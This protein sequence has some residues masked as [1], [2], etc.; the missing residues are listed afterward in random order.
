MWRMMVWTDS[1]QIIHN[2]A[3]WSSPLVHRLE[4]AFFGTWHTGFGRGGYIWDW[5]QINYSTQ[6]M[7]NLSLFLWCLSQEWTRADRP[8]A[9]TGT[10]T[11][12]DR[13][14]SLWIK[15]FSVSDRPSGWLLSWLADPGARV[16]WP[17]TWEDILQNMWPESLHL[18]FEGLR[19]FKPK[20]T[21]TSL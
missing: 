8:G 5:S 12:Q 1:L 7:S 6:W 20:R 18:E 11:A 21:L 10:R 15:M 2:S 3:F 14:V 13:R 19:L 16:A 4:L 17:N 9:N